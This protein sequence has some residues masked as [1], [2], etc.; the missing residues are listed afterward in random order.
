MA[1]AVAMVMGRSPKGS[2]VEGIHKNTIK[3]NDMPEW[4]NAFPS[5]RKAQK[6]ERTKNE[7]AAFLQS[8]IDDVAAS[9]VDLRSDTVAALREAPQAV[10]NVSFY[11]A[12][13]RLQNG[14]S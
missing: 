6:E 4:R 12:I 13:N 8:Q 11:E 2:P 9:V 1:M 5:V 10:A 14:G 7:I 3:E